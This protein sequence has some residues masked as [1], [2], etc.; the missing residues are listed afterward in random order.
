MA[1]LFDHLV[2]A[3]KHHRRE[4]DAERLS[5]FKVDDQLELG[6][7]LDRNVGRF[8]PAQ[9]LVGELRGATVQVGQV[10]P[11]GHQASR[12]HEFS[13]RA[14]RR[15]SGSERQRA[16][17]YPVCVHKRVGNDEQRI[18][19]ALEQ[20]ERGGVDVRGLAHLRGCNVEAERPCGS[21]SVAHLQHNIGTAGI[22]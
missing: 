14:T 3:G 17:K 12:F 5:S 13:K 6:R 10:W 15:Q 9:N 11:I 8:R 22:A 16:D 19:P 18:R 7:L 4:R 21:L 2:G 20:V 1:S